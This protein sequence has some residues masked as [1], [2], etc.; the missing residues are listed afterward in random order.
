M[1]VT[2][3][4]ADAGWFVPFRSFPAAEELLAAIR[5]QP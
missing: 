4:V 3:Y 5:L 1:P 2:Q